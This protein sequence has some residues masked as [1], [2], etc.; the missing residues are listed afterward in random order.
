MD[1]TRRFPKPLPAVIRYLLLAFAA[2]CVALGIVGIFV[3]GLPTTVFILMAGWAAARSSPR[4]SLWL[5]SHPL[6]GSML[7]DWRESRSVSRRAKLS[8]TVMMVACAVILFLTSSR[9]WLAELISATMAV[10]LMW[11]WRR[12]EPAPRRHSECRRS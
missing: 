8:A 1:E 7:R 10:V 3:P 5:E 6:F 12:P 9:L 4:F 2:L 11:L